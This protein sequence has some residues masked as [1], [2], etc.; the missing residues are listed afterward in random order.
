[1]NQNFKYL[2][3]GTALCC[4]TLAAQAQGLEGIIVEEYHTVTQADADVINNDIAGSSFTIAPGSKVY[5][6]FV[7][8]APGYKLNQ[9]FGAPETSPGSGVS[10]NPLDFSTTTTFWNDDNFGA[11]IPGQTR[12]IDE[13]TAFDTYITVNTTGTSGGTAG[14]G[15]ATQQFGV[16][17]T[18]DT[19][20]D[21]TTCG[22]YPGFTG[23]D[24]SIPGTG[25]A[26]T[27]NIS[28]DMDLTA[29]TASAASFQV[30]DDAWTTLPSSQGVDP[31]GTNRVLIGQFTTNGTFSFHINVQL[32]DPNSQLETYVWNQAGA[33]EQVSPFLTYPQQLP[34]DCNGV[35]GGSA[36]PGTPCD[37]GLATTGNDTWDA[38]CVCI[39]Q[40]IDCLGVPGGS[41]LPGTPCDD[42]LATTGNDTWDANCTCVGQL[43]DCLGVPGGSALPGT[44]CNDGNANTGNDTWDA[45]CTCVGQLID[46]LGVPGG[47]A[48]PGTACND[49]NANTGNDTW[50]ANCTCVGQLIDCLGVPGGS[51]LPGT[52]CDDGNPNS[53]ND[54]YDANCNCSGTLPN[55]CLGVP[56]GSAQPGTAC[57]D[58]L[59]TTGNDTWDANC[60]CVG[61]LI[62]CLG[63]PGGSALPGTACDDG[64]PNSSNDTYDAN[65]NCVGQLA[66]DCLGVPGGPAQP[67]TAC[68]DGLA[69]TGNDL[70]N[71]NCVCVGQL[72]DCEGTPGGSA[73]PGTSCDD[74]LATTG[75]DTWDANCT[76]VGQVIDCEGTAGGSALPGTPCDDGNPNSSNDTYDANCNCVGQLAND[77]LGV[78]GGPAQPGTAC[79]D[80]LATTGNDLWNANCVCVGQLI[81]CEG[82]PGGSALPGTACDDGNPNSSNDTWDANCSCVGQLASDCLG[83]PGGPAL[84]GTPCDDGQA[85]TGDDTWDANCNCIGEVIDCLGVPGGSALPGTAC[86]DGNAATI[87]Y[88]YDSNCT[89]AGTPIGNCTEILSLD[90]TLDNNGAETTWEVRDQSGTT[91]IASGG[92]YQNGQA[93]ITVTETLCLNQLCYRLIVNDAGGDGI[94][95]GGYVLTDANGRR[96]VDA[97]GSFASTSSV[98]NEFCLPL[99][100]ARLIN[101]S[102]DRTNL[103]YS[104]STQI[105]ASFY[106]GATGYQFWIF[107]PHGSYSRRV[108]KTTQNLV[109]ANLVTLPVPA[110]FDLNVRVRALVGGNYTEFGPACRFRLNTPGG[111]GREAVLFDEASNVTMSLYPNPNRGEVVNVAFDGIVAAERMDIDVMDLFGKR[112]M[113]EQIAAPGGAFVHTVDLS[114]LAPGVYMVNVRVGERLYTQRLVRQ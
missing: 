107:D 113:A 1:M 94:N 95:G 114:D 34:P 53:S 33:G 71:A 45:N 10:L 101:A 88:V 52:A 7:D 4:G 90:I 78:P 21:L 81:D 80:G 99:S 75:N 60:T 28:G 37:D 30:I 49:G 61:Q 31:S 40:L 86:D 70:W 102:C 15:S 55:D 66:N 41:A 48:L 74:G 17:R 5:R 76:C 69:T 19:N 51:A 73:L 32:S 18:A 42:G 110:D 27:Y 22:V 9:V 56:G 62:D 109:P 105:Y 8:M 43:I 65:C 26:L 14:C 106:P 54:V 13:G 85:Q 24:G 35:P 50:D 39:G 87:N 93:G 64:N 16:L 58:G 12:R 103:T 91:V 112:V 6:V 108:F 2:L 23:N 46:C 92:P 77:C 25:P 67:G 79:D 3:L 11:D 84:P 59:A 57:D 104:T 20:G 63:V 72:I 44:A 98:V 36:V 97:N 96:I 111:A 83:V 29:L 47:S 100:M 68:D 89:C 38:N 82:T